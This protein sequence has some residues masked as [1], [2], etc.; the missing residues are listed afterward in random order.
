MELTVL[1]VVTTPGSRLLV[2]M[3]CTC[4]TQRTDAAR[5]LA[6]LSIGIWP[7][8][9]EVTVAPLV[10]NVFVIPSPKK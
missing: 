9:S 6:L 3:V 5:L 2:D 1:S 4:L 8:V 10:E 7:I